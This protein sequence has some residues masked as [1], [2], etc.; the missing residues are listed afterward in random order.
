[1]KR[2]RSQRTQAEKPVE[3][4]QFADFQSDK[5]RAAYCGRSAEQE[6]IN[7]E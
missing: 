6:I 5:E 4:K 2:E 3:F 7:T 1:M